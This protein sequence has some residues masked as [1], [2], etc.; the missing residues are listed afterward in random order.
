MSAC[1]RDISQIA[2]IPSWTQ[3]MSVTGIMHGSTLS[4]SRVILTEEMLKRVTTADVYG[5]LEAGL[6]S[7]VGGTTVGMIEDRHVFSAAMQQETVRGTMNKVKLMD[8]I[9]KQVKQL[10]TSLS[11][12]CSNW[13][14]T[15]RRC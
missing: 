6:A 14:R 3:L 10:L 5:P 15:I 1:G 8:P 7:T 13:N 2:D 12:V 4:F 9:A 11:I